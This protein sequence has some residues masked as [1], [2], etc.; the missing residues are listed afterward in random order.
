MEE[1]VGFWPIAFAI[2]AVI[3]VFAKLIISE[4]IDEEEIDDFLNSIKEDDGE[5]GHK[6]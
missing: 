6:G 4:E 5:A 1:V 3:V 2:F